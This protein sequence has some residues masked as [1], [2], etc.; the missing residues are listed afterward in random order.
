MS[1]IWSNLSTKGIHQSVKTSDGNAKTHEHSADSLSRRYSILTPVKGGVDTAH[2]FN[3]PV[4]RSAGVGGQHKEIT[5]STTPI[6]RVSRFSGELSYYEPG[7][8][9]PE[10]KG[11]SARCPASPTPGHSPGAGNSSFPGK[12][13]SF[14]KSSLAGPLALQGTAENGELCH[15]SRPVSPRY[16]TEILCSSELDY[17]S[18]GRSKMVSSCRNV[19]VVSTGMRQIGPHCMGPSVSESG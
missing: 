14:I 12:S 13:D 11:D 9:N 3:L 16:D 10:E 7:P 2:S 17:R 18:K 5:V 4:I 8:T 15:T 6:N 19:E 1:P